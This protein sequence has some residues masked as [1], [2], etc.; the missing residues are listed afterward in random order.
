MWV[1]LCIIVVILFYLYFI[2]GSN[3]EVVGRSARI[4]NIPLKLFQLATPSP[5]TNVY[6]FKKGKD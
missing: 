5:S 3:L 4:T 2:Y 1:H 6:L